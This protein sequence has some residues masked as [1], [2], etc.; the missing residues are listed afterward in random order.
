M[1]GPYSSPEMV[2]ESVRENVHEKVREKVRENVR[3]FSPGSNPVHGKDFL[4]TNS[5]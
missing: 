3:E 2:H 1:K 4:G 5:A